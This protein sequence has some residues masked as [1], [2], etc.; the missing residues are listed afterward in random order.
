MGKD[1]HKK[2]KNKMEIKNEKYGKI[3]IKVKI[4]KMVKDKR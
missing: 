1:K 3:L 2:G 4:I